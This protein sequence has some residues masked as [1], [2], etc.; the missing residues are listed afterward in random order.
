MNTRKFP[1]FVRISAL[2]AGLAILAASGSAFAASGGGGG[3]GGGGGGNDGGGG[4]D[5]QQFGALVYKTNTPQSPKPKI[6]RTRTIGTP[7][8]GA[9]SFWICW[10]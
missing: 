1:A 3:N 6:H 10:K 4:G 5:G 9:D 2:A 8:C 7:L